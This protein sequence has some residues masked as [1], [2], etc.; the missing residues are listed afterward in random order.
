LPALTEAQH[1][2]AN[3]TPL[4]VNGQQR[5]FNDDATNFFELKAE[6]RA[7]ITERCEEAVSLAANHETSVYWVNLNDE[8]N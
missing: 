5:M 8:G 2:V 6:V 1:I 3:K 7:T 4:I